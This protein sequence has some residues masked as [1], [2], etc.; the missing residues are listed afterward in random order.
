MTSL[1]TGRVRRVSL[2]VQPPDLIAPVTR[3]YNH[4]LVIFFLDRS[5]FFFSLISISYLL[6]WNLNF[7]FLNY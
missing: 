2:A 6:V 5:S 3:K 1:V 7:S 4:D